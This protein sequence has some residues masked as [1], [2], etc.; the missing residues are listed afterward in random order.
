M[1]RLVLVALAVVAYEVLAHW[2]T[3]HAAASPWALVI[4]WGPLLLSLAGYAAARRRWWLLLAAIGGLV[5]V[6]VAGSVSD[7]QR[8]YLFQHAGIHAV[9]GL[10]FA[11][12]LLPGR[13]PMITK[14]ALRVHGGRMPEAKFAYTRRV[15][16][17]WVAYFAAM[18]AASL[19]LYAWAPWA[20]WSAFANLVTP[21]AM[22]LMLVGEWRLRYWLHPEFERVPITTAMRAFRQA[23]AAGTP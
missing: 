10:V 13:M 8:L 2:L 23:P 9:L 6:A 18:V 15:T 7:L 16:Q 22:V 3:V 17:A 12:T 5:F 14:V 4:V 19:A 21:A 20:W 11:A 1:G